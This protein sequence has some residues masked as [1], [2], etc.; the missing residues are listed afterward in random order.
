MSKEKKFDQMIIKERKEEEIKNG[1]T[2]WRP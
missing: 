2:Q 1:R